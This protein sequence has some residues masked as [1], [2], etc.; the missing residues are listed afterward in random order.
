LAATEK[1]IYSG[2][3]ISDSVKTIN[4]SGEIYN[5][6]L[7]DS[8]TLVV[9]LPTQETLIVDN[10]SCS[11]KGIYTICLNETASI[12]FDID[13][14]EDMAN[15]SIH[16][17]KMMDNPAIVDID[18]T[19]S[20]VDVLIEEKIKLGIKLRNVGEETATNLHYEELIPNELKITTS[21]GCM[22][23]QEGQDFSKIFWDGE[24]R[25][26]E[27]HKCSISLTPIGPI[28]YD[29]FGS[30]SYYDGFKTIETDTYERSINVSEYKLKITTESNKKSYELEDII[31]I[32][33]TLENIDDNNDIIINELKVDPSPGLLTY[34]STD[35]FTERNNELTWDGKISSNDSKE[36]SFSLESR[37][38]RKYIFPI[39]VTYTIE[40]IRKTIEQNIS[41]TMGDVEEEAPKA[42][43]TPTPIPII[44]IEEEIEEEDI[45]E[46]EKEEEIDNEVKE[47]TNEII[48][49]TENENNEDIKENENNTKEGLWDNLSPYLIMILEILLIYIIIRAIHNLKAR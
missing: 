16:I 28:I 2:T 30:I 18:R 5:L 11:S 36:F 24:L 44:Q 31:I 22:I 35:P 3:I 7:K 42:T 6:D 17:Y 27:L 14:Q 26:D 33:I 47:K 37:V 23:T 29:S 49:N 19:I 39:I 38:E 41:F 46:E 48:T 13:L 20:P 34:G 40:G 4:I 21:D 43:P 9:N 15:G 45:A 8:K 10:K 32:D 25:K 1:F 12:Y